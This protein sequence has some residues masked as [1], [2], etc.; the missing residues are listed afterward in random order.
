MEE[1]LERRAARLARRVRI[2]VRLVFYPA[3]LVLI[4]IAWQHYHGHDASARGTHIVGWAGTTSQG[5]PIRAITGDGRLVYLG[6]PLVERCSD[7][8]L[9]TFDWEPGEPRFVQ[10]GVVVEG[11]TVGTTH[12]GARV[13]YDNRLSLRL[14]DEP[15]GT[16]SG[17]SL[18]SN[19]VRCDSGP[20]TF[21]LA[22]APKPE[23]YSPPGAR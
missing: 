2:G 20:I 7:N 15:Y 22:R 13:D 17:Q 8:S 3:A 10:H 6:A 5:R 14:G 11:R 4:V 16:L 1:D 19:G 9:V 21:R 18:Y 23:R 12:V